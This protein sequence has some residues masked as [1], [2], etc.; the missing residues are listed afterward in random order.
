MT[1]TTQKP[2][3]EIEPEKHTV[4]VRKLRK[5]KAGE[6][7]PAKRMAAES[8][9]TAAL[10]AQLA[11]AHRI[12]GY[13]TGM[14]ELSIQDEEAGR[15]ASAIGDLVDH[16][17]LTVTKPLVLWVNLLTVAGTIYVPRI[18]VIR[19]KRAEARKA[20]QTTDVLRELDKVAPVA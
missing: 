1:E 9:D 5:P 10:A 7:K 17:G 12:L 13:V 19:H 11:M 15:L 16:Y 2:T 3:L 8:V 14:P 20:Q 6:E 4:K 18:I